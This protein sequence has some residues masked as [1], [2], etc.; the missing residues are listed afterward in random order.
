M[1]VVFILTNYSKTWPSC[2]SMQTLKCSNY[3][4][5]VI[6]TV[7]LEVVHTIF[8]YDIRN[9]DL[10]GGGSTESVVEGEV[11]NEFGKFGGPLIVNWSH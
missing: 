6:Q 2:V 10:G 4:C 3:V 7:I 9:C 11:T 5:R 1:A 8:F